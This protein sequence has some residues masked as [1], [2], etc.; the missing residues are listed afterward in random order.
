M[1]EVGERKIKK[2]LTKKKRV[3]KNKGRKVFIINFCKRRRDANFLKQGFLELYEKYAKQGKTQKALQ[4]LRLATVFGKIPEKDSQWALTKVKE[5]NITIGYWVAEAAI[6]YTR[7]P[8]SN[9]QSILETAH[10]KGDAWSGVIL[11]SMD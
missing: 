9:M 7:R 6:E 11:E 1:E 4:M 5:E 10:Q 8:D 3:R 2:G